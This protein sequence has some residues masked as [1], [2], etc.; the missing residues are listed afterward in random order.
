MSEA[1]A[2]VMPA[3]DDMAGMRR[4]EAR[5]LPAAA[6]DAQTDDRATIAL[7]LAG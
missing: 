1:T 6:P 5:A 4:V 3:P 2:D 7:R